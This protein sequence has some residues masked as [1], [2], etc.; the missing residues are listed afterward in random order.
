MLFSETF[1]ITPT[2][3]LA[4]LAW[5]LLFTT[6]LYFTREPAHRVI[7]SLS[8]V[9]RRGLRLMASA[10][11]RAEERL[12]ARNREVLLAAGREA[13]ER[14]VEREFQRIDAAVNRDLAQ[15][16]AL[17]RRLSEQIA[18]IEEDHAE[19]TEVPPA[20]P[21]WVDAVQAVANIPFNGDPVVADILG[22]VKDSLVEAQQRAIAE[23]RDATKARHDRL[24]DMLPQWRGVQQMLRA[25]DRNVNT[26]IGRSKVI[27]RH[28]EEY[29]N[30]VHQSDR[31][32]R[33]LSSSSLVQFFIAALVLAIAVGGAVINFH[34]IARPMAEMVGNDSGIGS[35]RISDVAALVIILVEMSMGLF[36]MESLRITRLFPVI[37]ALPDVLR[38]RMI[39]MTLT[40]LFGLASVEAGL[41]YMREILLQDELATNALLRSEAATLLTAEFQWITTAA[42][43]GMGFILPFA[44]VFVAIP[45]EMF[46]SSLRTVLGMIG[47][48]LLRALAVTLRVSGNAASHLGV[49]TI[50]IYDLLIFGPLW[51]EDRLG[52]QVERRADHDHDAAHEL[53]SRQEYV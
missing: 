21:G 16:P 32:L 9:L 47:Q 37:G 53:A 50:A 41:A 10:V 29:E 31:A 43:M 26:L 15:C 40:I 7:A 13:A 36:L 20:P 8:R 24:S 4:G 30:V 44:L 17:E 27:D 46:V 45:L 34:L 42:Q 39:W 49:V 25:L 18:K 5:F 3:A 1:D 38:V 14:I 28:M 11:M 52:K 33:T 48:A 51:L 23:Y 22:Q 2:S 12:R 6:A 35:F 19:S